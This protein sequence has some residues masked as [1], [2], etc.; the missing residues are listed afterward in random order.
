MISHL[1]DSPWRESHEPDVQWQRSALR[2]L[3]RPGDT[4]SQSCHL[5]LKG[6][7]EQLDLCCSYTSPA[8]VQPNVCSCPTQPL[9]RGSQGKR[10]KAR[11]EHEA[12]ER[13]P[14]ELHAADSYVQI[15]GQPQAWME[16][17]VWSI[18]L[19]KASLLPDLP[20]AQPLATLGSAAGKLWA[21]SGLGHGW[22]GHTFRKCPPE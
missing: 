20:E 17:A 1:N 9:A 3:G 4:G 15:P 19:C 14:R 12:Q 22:L 18:C 2:W 8:W 10:G 6:E 5:L 13:W 16:P 11:G 21:H 7:Q